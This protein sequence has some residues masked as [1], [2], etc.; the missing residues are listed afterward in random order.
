MPAEEQHLVP[1]FQKWAHKTNKC[2]MEERKKVDFL[3]WRHGAGQVA[4]VMADSSRP[5]EL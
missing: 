2:V 3:H 5:Y 4:A 1:Q